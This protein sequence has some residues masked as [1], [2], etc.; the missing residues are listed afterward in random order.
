MVWWLKEKE[1]QE[2]REKEKNRKIR[3]FWKKK[4]QMM[5]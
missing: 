2:M 3:F 1:D 4:I 5:L